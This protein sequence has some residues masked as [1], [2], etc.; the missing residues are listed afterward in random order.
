MAYRRARMEPR[1][2]D[3]IVQ[4]DAFFFKSGIPE[5]ARKLGPAGGRFVIARG[6]ATGHA[7]VA[8]GEIEVYEQNGV[9]YLKVTGPAEVTHEEHLPLPLPPGTWEV[10][11]VREFDPF[12]EECRN[13][14][15]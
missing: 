5:A 4:G 3:L 1:E 11:V 13:V 15:D 12:L 2:T 8:G 6:E 9:L 7:H 10:G 14:A